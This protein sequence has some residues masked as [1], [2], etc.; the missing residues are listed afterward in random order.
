[1]SD[2]VAASLEP[3]R[4][5][6]A[7]LGGF[8]A[9]AMLL[10]AIGLYGVISYSVTQR[11]QEIGIRIALGAQRGEVLGLVIRQGMQLAVIGLGI[12]LVLSLA[13]SRLLQNQLFQIS[14]LDPP[15]FTV[16]ALILIAAALLACY[17]PARRAMRVDPVDAL[18]YE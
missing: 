7:L 15:T 16:T 1:M 12:G 6:V 13:S 17:I 10:A 14:A 9:M 3:R 18:R 8:A 5:V 4:F 2:M 11:T